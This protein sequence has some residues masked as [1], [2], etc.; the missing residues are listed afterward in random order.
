MSGGLDLFASVLFIY[1]PI[2]ISLL[3]IW[4]LFWAIKNKRNIYV[5]PLILVNLSIITHFVGLKVIRGF[6]GMGVSML[7][8]ILLGI[9]LIILVLILIT[10]SNMKRKSQRSI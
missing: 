9:C 4:G 3:S 5:P 2:S 1:L 6:E 10:D 8:A 7:G